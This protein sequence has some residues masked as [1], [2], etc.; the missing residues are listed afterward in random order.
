MPGFLLPSGSASE[1]FGFSPPPQ[2]HCTLLSLSPFSPATYWPSQRS[3]ML[4]GHCIC[5]SLFECCHPPPSTLDL[6]TLAHSLVLSDALHSQEPFFDHTPRWPLP[7]TLSLHAL[8]FHHPSNIS[9][10]FQHISVL[11]GLLAFHRINPSAHL[12]IY[13]TSRCSIHVW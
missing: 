2:P 5:H 7:F 6:L 3:D 1:R 9:S 10:S 12:L 13:S 11:C 4:H 8:L